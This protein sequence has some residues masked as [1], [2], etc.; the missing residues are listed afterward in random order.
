MAGARSRILRHARDVVEEWNAQPILQDALRELRPGFAAVM[1]E[2]AQAVYESGNRAQ[3][4][5]EGFE[6][7]RESGAHT[8]ELDSSELVR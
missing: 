2:L 8:H 4:R 1:D 6:A 5:E 3:L 7:A